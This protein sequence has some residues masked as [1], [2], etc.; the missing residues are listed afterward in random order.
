M[1]GL[2]GSCVVITEVFPHR[3]YSLYRVHAQYFWPGTRR[4]FLEQ[5]T[6]KQ[7]L[8]ELNSPEGIT[9]STLIREKCA[10]VLLLPLLVGRS[11]YSS[12]RGL[13]ECWAWDVSPSGIARLY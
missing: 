2:V 9:T 7:V 4:L 13:A 12:Y 8:K 1:V 11:E 10:R 3:G 5:S 6:G